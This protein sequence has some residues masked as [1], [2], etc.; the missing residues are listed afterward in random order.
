[1]SIAQD[2]YLSPLGLNIA[3]G[4]HRVAFATRKQRMR[5]ADLLVYPYRMRDSYAVRGKTASAKGNSLAWLGEDYSRGDE[6]NGFL[7]AGDFSHSIHYKLVQFFHG[8][9]LG[10]NAQ[11]IDPEGQAGLAY[12]TRVPQQIENLVFS[13]RFYF[14]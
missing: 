5:G 13:S 6:S 3:A 12:L 10:F 2:V 1:M 8:L 9:E 14:R 4:A 11:I 7:D